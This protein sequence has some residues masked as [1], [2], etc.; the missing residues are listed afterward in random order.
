MRVN[1][2]NRT[3]NK[4]DGDGYILVPLQSLIGSVRGN[5]LALSL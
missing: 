5:T 2:T 3:R 4:D 1:K